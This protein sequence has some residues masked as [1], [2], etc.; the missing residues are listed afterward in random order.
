VFTPQD[1]ER[2]RSELLEAAR[3]DARLSG[4]AIT[5]SAAAGR[6]DAW[7]D[8]DLAFGVVE[9]MRMPEVLANWTSRMVDRYQAVDHLD[10]V[11]GAWVYRVFLLASTLQVDLAFAPSAEF[12]ARAPTF[13]LVFGKAAE[14][15]HATPLRAEG[16][17]GYA[18]LYALHARSALA[19]GRL[20]Q[21]EYM[22]SAVR[23]HVLAL[24]CARLGLP[25][26]EGR[27]MDQLP[28]DV[29]SALEPALVRRLDADDIVRAFRV[30]TEALIA[31]VERVDRVLAGRLAA[32]LRELSEPRN[33]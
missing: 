30:A 31:E 10:V 5:G 23:D 21:A 4:G 3:A 28:K 15:K 12:G 18:W 16:L 25:E 19:R 29:T 17:I 11:H 33:G 24:A 6:E 9:P 2:I 22:V 20:W 8:V 27:G 13:R 1:R 32:T 14:L 26:R 7:S